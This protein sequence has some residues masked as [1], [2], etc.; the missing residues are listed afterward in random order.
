MA[1]LCFFH[2][3]FLSFFTLI[4]GLGRISFTGSDSRDKVCFFD[5]SFRARAHIFSS[6]FRDKDVSFLAQASNTGCVSFSD[7]GFR[8]RVFSDW[9]VSCSSCPYY[10]KDCRDQA[11]RGHQ[12]KPH[13][14]G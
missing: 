1:K 8:V 7:S 11:G 3:L 14:K 13:R 9:L 10:P 5:S 2:W 12:R 4:L 6:E